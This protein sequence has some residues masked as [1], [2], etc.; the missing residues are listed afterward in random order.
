MSNSLTVDHLALY[1]Q[2]L[3]THYK[4]STTTWIWHKMTDTEEVFMQNISFEGQY[5]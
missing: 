1:L 4:T 3:K 2:I 5:T